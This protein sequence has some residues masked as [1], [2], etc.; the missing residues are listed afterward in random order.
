MVPNALALGVDRAFARQFGREKL[1]E[2]PYLSVYGRTALS[3]QQWNELLR[4][5]VRIL[6]ERQ[7]KLVWEKLFGRK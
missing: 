6:D 5:V 4:Q 1:P 2:C 7:R 3:A